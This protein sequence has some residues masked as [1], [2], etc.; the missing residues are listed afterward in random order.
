MDRMTLHPEEGELLDY[1]FDV[2]LGDSSQLEEDTHGVDPTSDSSPTGVGV[3]ASHGVDSVDCALDSLLAVGSPSRASGLDDANSFLLSLSAEASDIRAPDVPAG[4]DTLINSHLN[5]N[6]KLKNPDS[7]NPSLKVAEKF[8]N[9]GVPG[10]LPGLKVNTVKDC[11]YKVLSAV[12]KRINGDLQIAEAC[13][14]KSVCAQSQALESMLKLRDSLN[15]EQRLELE[16]SI[17]HTAAAI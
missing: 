12:P 8:K 15:R 16:K 14:C 17:K 6:F 10:N 13:L 7:I 1:D 9:Y 4:I 5:R 3:T 11:V 2:V